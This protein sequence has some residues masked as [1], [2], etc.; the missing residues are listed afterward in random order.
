[1][2][3]EFYCPTLN[4]EQKRKVAEGIV[5][6]LSTTLNHPKD[7]IGVEFKL[8]RPENLYFGGKFFTERNGEEGYHLNV[9]CPTTSKEMKKELVQKLTAKIEKTLNLPEY[10]VRELGITI[11]ELPYENLGMGGRMLSEMMAGTR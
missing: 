6:V 2:F 1:M 9:F 7:K 5:E 10:A 11:H 3:C 8:Y 4:Q